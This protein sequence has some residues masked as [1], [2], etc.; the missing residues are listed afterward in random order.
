MESKSTVPT[1]EPM[2]VESAVPKVV[3]E[4]AEINNMP[5]SESLRPNH[6]FQGGKWVVSK[7]R[8]GVTYLLKSLHPPRLRL[9]K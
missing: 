1:S 6:G 5:L 4:T 2:E 8:N 9:K 7:S 3:P